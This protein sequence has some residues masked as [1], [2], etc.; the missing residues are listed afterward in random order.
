MGGGRA[1][2]PAGGRGRSGRLGRLP[3]PT[4]A[5]RAPRAGPPEDRSAPGPAAPPGGEE[6]PPAP[7]VRSAV[8]A[9]LRSAKLAPGLG[10]RVKWGVFTEEVARPG[11]PPPD[12]EAP[13]AQRLREAAASELRN[14]DAAERGR[15]GQV[16]AA[17]LAL[18]AVVAAGLWSAGAPGW[19]RFALFYPTF[20]TGAGFAASARLGL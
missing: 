12:P 3:G 10:R 9:T 14:I 16:G 18:S 7:T 6:A 8:A 11:A 4:R 2:R 19:L 20:A 17:A 15:R 5:P 13:A 1:P